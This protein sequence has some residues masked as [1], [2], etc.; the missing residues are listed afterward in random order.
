MMS[1]L[2]GPI[3]PYKKVMPG[4]SEDANGSLVFNIADILAEIGWADTP[5]NRAAVGQILRDQAKEQG[6]GVLWRPPEDPTW[7]EG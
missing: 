6:M 1:G 2:S 3:G 5:E 7:R 4:V